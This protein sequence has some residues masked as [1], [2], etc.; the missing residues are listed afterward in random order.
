MKKQDRKHEKN[1]PT[2]AFVTYITIIQT[3]NSEL[4]NTEL[5]YRINLDK[6][7]D[8]CK[9][10]WFGSAD[11]TYGLSPGDI[12]IDETEPIHFVQILFN[13]KEICY[14][15]DNWMLFSRNG[16]ISIMKNQESN[17]LKDTRWWGK[18]FTNEFH[19]QIDFFIKMFCEVAGYY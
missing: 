17:Y 12:I 18:S 11:T 9:K 15:D 4:Y 1:S 13:L 6:L 19:S 16:L 3:M 2:G 7:Q 8:G 14:Q 5:L 10:N